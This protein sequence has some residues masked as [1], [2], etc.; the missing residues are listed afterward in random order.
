[1]DELIMSVSGDVV[2]WADAGLATLKVKTKLGFA[3]VWVWE[4]ISVKFS[5]GD[6]F[7]VDDAPVAFSDGCVIAIIR[8][9]VGFFL[10]NIKYE[11]KEAP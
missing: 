10:N 4:E 5:V 7:Q 3:F 2:E 1:M 8:P 6:M 9:G 11:T